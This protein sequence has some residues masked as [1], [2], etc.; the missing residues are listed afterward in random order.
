MWQLPVQEMIVFMMSSLMYVAAAVVGLVQLSPKGKPCAR[1][2]VPLICLAVCLQAV[3]LVFRAVDIKAVPLTGLFESM[4]VLTIVLSL[5][6]I[7]LSIAIPQVWFGSIMVWTILV[8]VILGAV[9]AQPASVPTKVAATPW[10]IFHASAM[11]LSS[12]LIVFSTASAFL[13][14]L[15]CHRLKHKKVMTVLGRVPNLEWLRRANRLGLKGCFV[16]Q[17]VGLACGIGM[18]AVQSAALGMDWVDW[19]TDAKIVLIAIA[20]AL[21]L[22]ILCLRKLAGISDKVIAYITLLLFFLII[23]AS[24]GV[25][26]FCGTKHVFNV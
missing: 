15:S 18:A 5:I 24:V 16:A 1:A 14:L 4:L 20:W 17:T 13:Y 6:Y 7:F 12:A 23:F 2:L 8:L 11:V 3:V 19:L 10:V 22:I 21:L 26:L 9:V 25:A